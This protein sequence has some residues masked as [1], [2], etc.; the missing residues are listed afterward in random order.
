MLKL[1]GLNYT[2]EIMKGNIKFLNLMDSFT[3]IL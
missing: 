3:K 1:S 2:N